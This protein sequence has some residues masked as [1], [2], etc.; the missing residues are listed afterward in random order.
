MGSVQVGKGGEKPQW[1]SGKWKFLP[2]P[3]ILSCSEQLGMKLE[4]KEGPWAFPVAGRHWERWERRSRGSPPPP[5]PNLEDRGGLLL[6]SNP[7]GKGTLG[8]RG[9]GCMEIGIRGL[10]KGMGG[11]T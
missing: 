6:R 4:I 8:L 1:V 7:L 10:T 9:V 11:C 2:L 5:S 3:G